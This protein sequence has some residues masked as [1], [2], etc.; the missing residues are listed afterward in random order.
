VAHRLPERSMRLAFAWMIL[1]T[2]LWML[3]KPLILQGPW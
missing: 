1:A 3:L 2:A